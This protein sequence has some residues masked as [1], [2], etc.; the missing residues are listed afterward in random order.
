MTAPAELPGTAGTELGWDPGYPLDLRLTLGP[1]LRGPGDPTQLVD[2][3]GRWWRACR[4][5]DGP[6]T[7]VIGRVG[8]RVAARAWG[9]GAGWLLASV[10]DLLGVRDEPSAFVAHHPPVAQAFRRHPG[11]RVPR[12]GLVMESLVP[13]ILEQL[14]TGMEATRSWRELVSRFGEPAPGPVPRGLTVMPEPAAWV[15]LPD[16]EWHRAGVDGRRR[17]TLVAVARLAPAL[18]RTVGLSP[19]EAKLLLRTVPGVGVWTAAEVACR[20]YGDADAVSVGD[21]HLAAQIGWAMLGRPV[22]DRGMLELLEPY[23]PQRYRAI[24]LILMSG[25]GQPRFA[26]RYAPRDNRRI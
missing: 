19:V 2:S 24:R 23:R 22:D 6:G 20:A 17:Q 9:P 1:L 10:P 16:W 11:L 21:Y 12:T 7:L 5:P 26:P 3:A 13:A 8:E 4:T 14:V 25:P 15:R 18:E